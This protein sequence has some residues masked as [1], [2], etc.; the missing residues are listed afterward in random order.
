VPVIL[1]SEAR[2]LEVSRALLERGIVAPA[3]RPPTVPAG[4]SRLRLSVR[5][6]HRAEQIDRLLEELATCTVTS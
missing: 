2:A 3:V 5:S 1:G 4:G 6:D